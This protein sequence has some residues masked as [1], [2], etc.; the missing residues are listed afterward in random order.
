MEICAGVTVGALPQP[1]EIYPP[2]DGP[3]GI[4]RVSGQAFQAGFTTLISLM[5]LI[6]LNLGILNLLPIPILDGG[7]MLLLI[8]EGVIRQ[9]LSLAI[10]ER[11]V[12]V[13]FVFLLLVTAFVFYNDIVKLL[14]YNQPS[15]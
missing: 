15:P 11:I 5:A 9:D 6:S 2:L 14:P 4:V 8:V 1:G 10:K 12:Q 3:I 7:V 13:G